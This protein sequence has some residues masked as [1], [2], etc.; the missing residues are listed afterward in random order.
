MAGPQPR[1]CPGRRSALTPSLAG[2]ALGTDSDARRGHAAA[3]RRGGPRRPLQRGD[4]VAACRTVCP[5]SRDVRHAALSQVV[6]ITPGQTVK[7]T[8]L[9]PFKPADLTVTKTDEKTGKPL[10][11]AVIYI[12]PASGDAKPVT[13]TMGKDGPPPSCPSPR[14]R[15]PPTR[16][17]SRRGAAV[18]RASS[19]GSHQVVHCWAGPC[20]RSPERWGSGRSRDQRRVYL[21]AGPDGGQCGEDTAAAAER[22]QSL[23]CSAAPCRHACQRVS[24]ASPSGGSLVRD[25]SGRCD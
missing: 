6:I 9:D 24:P 2:L 17:P 13:L 5:C 22:V 23:S 14:A 20:G 25:W 3:A 18:G 10:A 8:I 12:T 16:R 15:A 21:P 4:V 1:T 7:L 11:G 19:S